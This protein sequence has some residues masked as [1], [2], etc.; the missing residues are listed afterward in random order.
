[1]ITLDREVWQAHEAEHVERA[2]RLTQARRMRTAKG[3]THAVE[4]FLFTYYPLKPA[5]LTR[6]S[7]GAGIALA[8]AAGSRLASARW[9]TLH[10]GA[11]HLDVAAYLSDRGSA[12]RF[13]H[14]LLSAIDS[15]PPRFDCFGLHEWAMVYGE[16]AGQHRH[17]L[18]LRLSEAET[19][20]V[21]TSHKIVCSHID[22]FRFFTPPAIGF[23][24]MT[25]T[26]ETQVEMDQGGCLHVGMDL[27]KTTIHLGPAVPG[28]LALDVVELARDI[29][30]LDMRASPYDV[31]RYGLS[32]VAIETAEGKADYVA[33]QRVLAQR[34]EPLR[35]RLRDVCAGLLKRDARADGSSRVAA[36]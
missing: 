4:D 33:A 28:D 19:D 7:P 26:R 34:A 27:V 12:V 24:T 25:P 2:Q 29:R 14:T 30:E 20:T 32:A 9:F 3:E 36:T 23:N 18:P 21:V 1:M 6:W 13:H 5:L 11:A 35:A 15:R 10:D 17:D 22:A 31:S 8:D 16:A